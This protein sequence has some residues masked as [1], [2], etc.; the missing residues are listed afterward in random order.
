MD[1]GTLTSAATFVAGVALFVGWMLTRRE[2]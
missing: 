2:P 1:L